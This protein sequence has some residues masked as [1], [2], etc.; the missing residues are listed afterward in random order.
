[1]KQRNFPLALMSHV[2]PIHSRNP[3]AAQHPPPP[4]YP[5]IECARIPHFHPI[6]EFL[7]RLK[8]QEGTISAVTAEKIL[9]IGWLARYLFSILAVWCVLLIGVVVSIHCLFGIGSLITKIGCIIDEIAPCG[10]IKTVREVNGR[11]C[12]VFLG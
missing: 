11:I 4:F 10:E 7:G 12:S 2:V 1:M 8:P 9:Y 3:I 5:D 6:L